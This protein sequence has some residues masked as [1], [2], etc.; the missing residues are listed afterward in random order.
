ML[1]ANPCTAINENLVRTLKREHDEALQSD[2][3]ASNFLRFRMNINA[4]EVTHAQPLVTGAEWERVCARPVPEREG[5][6]VIS[7]D[8][9]GN[10][11]WSAAV[12]C[13]SSGRIEAWCL[14]PGQ[15][16]LAAQEADDQ[17]PDGSYLELVRS[18]GLS[19]DEGQHV[20]SIEKLLARVWAWSPSCIVC[21][22]YRSA[23]LNQVVGWSSSDR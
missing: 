15:P 23:E 22:P 17:V 10:R 19:I 18:G 8:L 7:V 13:W 14:A 9:G 4:P 12:G 21:D 3:A 5:K 6:P 11:S 2:R 1:K 20:P 16:S